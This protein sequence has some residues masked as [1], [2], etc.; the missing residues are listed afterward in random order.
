VPIQIIAL[1]FT[2]ESARGL[3]LLLAAG[4]V[5]FALSVI[6]HTIGRLTR[7]PRRTYASAVSRGR[8]GDPSELPVP[9]E[10]RSWTF[11]SRGRDMP[12]W[13]I[14]CGGEDFG[15]VN[16]ERP[17]GSPS[18]TGRERTFILTHGWGDSRIGG[19]SR[20][21]FFAPL[22]SRLILW[23]MPGHG[24]SPGVCSLGT[25]EVDD[26]LALI[27]H[28]CGPGED[29]VL[30]GWSLGAGVSIAAAR[31]ASGNDGAAGARI[32]GVIAESPY[33]LAATPAKNV[34]RE[35]RMPYR[36]NVPAALWCIGVEA[37]VG[38]RWRGFDRAGLA[39]RLQCPLLVI[40][41]EEDAI[42]PLEDGRAIASAARGGEVVAIP[43]AGH[44]G[45]WTDAASASI[46]GAAVRRFASALRSA[47]A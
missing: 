45:I 34:L 29:V 33:R 43:G 39:A 36:W 25:G 31:L 3:A 20:I 11:R 12:A 37:G 40:H 6:G 17:D 16:R 23:D 46:A 14:A 10:F 30:V 2:W 28:S 35:R 44:H 27:E 1:S 4:W 5:L 26:L 13:E 38:I 47:G 8:P 18:G 24:E 9:R 32:V 21:E 19:L 42:S 15:G 22:A 7:P 41:G